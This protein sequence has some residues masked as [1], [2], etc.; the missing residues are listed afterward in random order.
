M[1]YDDG[2]SMADGWGLSHLS[3]MPIT[4]TYGLLLLGVLVL[5]VLMKILFADVSVRAGGGVR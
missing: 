5:L 3:T 2:T 1:A 4:M